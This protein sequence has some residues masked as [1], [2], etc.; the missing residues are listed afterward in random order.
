MAGMAGHINQTPQL[1]I[2]QRQQNLSRHV[3]A[4]RCPQN[5]IA[6]EAYTDSSTI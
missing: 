3:H 4:H 1:I 6:K 2:G 5:P